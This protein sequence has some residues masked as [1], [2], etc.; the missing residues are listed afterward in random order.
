MLSSS[1]RDYSDWHYSGKKCAWSCIKYHELFVP[2]IPHTQSQ[3]P[4]RQ[5]LNMTRP[6]MFRKWSM[7]QQIMQS[8]SHPKQQCSSV[9]KPSVFGQVDVEISVKDIV[10]N[11]SGIN[12]VGWPVAKLDLRLK[13]VR[14]QFRKDCSLNGGCLSSHHYGSCCALLCHVSNRLSLMG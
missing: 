2:I 6:Q 11:I 3:L 12:F 8:E 9:S 10:V 5:M 4:S 1:F 7:M 13:H 14:S